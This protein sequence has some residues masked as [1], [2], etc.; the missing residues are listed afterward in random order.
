MLIEGNLLREY[1][2]QKYYSENITLR[3]IFLN[4]RQKYNPN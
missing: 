3:I 1:N 2:S 4:V